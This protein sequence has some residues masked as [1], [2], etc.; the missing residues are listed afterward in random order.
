NSMPVTASVSVRPAAPVFYYPSAES[1]VAGTRGG[2]LAKVQSSEGVVE[3]VREV[4]STAAD[5]DQRYTFTNVAAG[6]DLVLG[7]NAWTSFSNPGTGDEYHPQYW[8]KGSTWVDLTQIVARSSR[9]VTRTRFEANEP[10]Q[11]WSLPSTVSGTVYIRLT[12]V[13][14]SGTDAVDTLSVDEIFL[15]SVVTFPTVSVAAT[16]NG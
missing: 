7:L 1:T 11:M 13:N 2:S 8:T 4:I 6:T 16:A 3:T 14:T 10:Y 9:D 15:R 5:V 12:D